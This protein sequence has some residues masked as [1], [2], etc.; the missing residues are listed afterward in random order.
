MASGFPVYS[1]S[2]YVDPG[3]LPT[4]LV[5][6]AGW[7][8]WFNLLKV[9]LEWSS[10][11]ISSLFLGGMLGISILAMIGAIQ[12]FHPEWWDQWLS[13]IFLLIF[14]F[15]IFYMLIQRRIKTS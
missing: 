4:A 6:C 10:V 5:L 1:W 11:T 13:L 14:Q 2:R 8:E 15:I 7:W 3:I 9:K 12:F